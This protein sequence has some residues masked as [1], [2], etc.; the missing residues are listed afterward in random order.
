M[1]SAHAV[2]AGRAY[3]ELFAKTTEF[4]RNFRSEINSLSNF[5]RNASSIADRI[6]T[7][8][9]VAA[10][11]SLYS[12]GKI[13]KSYADFD[14][15]LKVVQATT[16]ATAEEYKELTSLA[17][18]LGRTTS[19]TA[20]EV[21]SGMAQLG[22]A[23]FDSNEIQATLKHFLN[24]SRAT[25]TSLPTAVDIATAT[26]RGFNM[27]V[28]QA[29]YIADVLTATANSSAQTLEDLGEAFKYI[30]PL[31]NA[32]SLSLKETA[33]A[34]A[35]LANLGIKGSM[36]A[37][38]M[39]NILLR[40]SLPNIQEIYRKE[41][42][43]EV[44]DQETGAL[45]SFNEVMQD[46]AESLNNISSSKRLAIFRDLFG[47][48]GL[49]SGTAASSGIDFS[50]MFEKID[51][52]FG[53]AQ[54][55]AD[56]MDEGIGGELRLT[57]SKFADIGI[58]IGDAL[59]PQL[60][61]LSASIEDI[62][63]K[64]SDFVR[65]SNVV[66]TIVEIGKGFASSVA[67][68]ISFVRWIDN[69]IKTLTLG[70]GSLL[71]FTGFFIQIAPL[72]YAVSRAFT[73][74][75]NSIIALA[76]GFEKLTTFFYKFQHLGNYFNNAKSKIGSFKTEFIKHFDS[77]TGRNL[78]ARDIALI[79]K[80]DSKI[81]NYKTKLEKQMESL[82][83][84]E[85]KK[86]EERKQLVDR[87]NKEWERLGQLENAR[88]SKQDW[89]SSHYASYQEASKN[90]GFYKSRLADLQY[91]IDKTTKKISSYTE[92]MRYASTIMNQQV[93]NYGE[94]NSKLKAVRA[95]IQKLENMK[96]QRSINE[97]TIAKL[98]DR[99]SLQYSLEANKAYYDRITK[100]R[101]SAQASLA[102]TMRWHPE[103]TK[104]IHGLRKD[105]AYYDN[106]IK[107]YDNSQKSV[108]GISEKI[109]A[110]EA[111]N[112]WFD[113]NISRLAE[114]T[115]REREYQA[116]LKSIDAKYGSMSNSAQRYRS[117]SESLKVQKKELIKEFKQAETQLES[118][119]K[120]LNA[121]TAVL[122]QSGAMSQSPAKQKKR[123]KKE[124]EQ[125]L[126]LE[127]NAR[128]KLDSLKKEI[129]LHQESAIRS[130][131]AILAEMKH[132]QAVIDN[133]IAVRNNAIA[134]KEQVKALIMKRVA[135]AALA[136]GVVGTF[137]AV[138]SIIGLASLKAKLFAKTVADMARKTAL[139]GERLAKEQEKDKGKMQRLEKI[140]E[141]QL[142]YNKKNE[143]SNSLLQ[144]AEKIIGS[145]TAKYGDLGLSI[146]ETT[147][148]V[149]G[150]TE[151]QGVLAKKHLEQTIEQKKE[152]R[153]TAAKQAEAKRLE[154]H[155][156][157][158]GNAGFHNIRHFFKTQYDE[159]GNP[160]FYGF[161]GQKNK[162]YFAIRDQA[163]YDRALAEADEFDLQ[164]RDI[165]NE[166]VELEKRLEKMGEIDSDPVQKALFNLETLK[167]SLAKSRETLFG[168]RETDY[169]AV[170]EKFRD[171]TYAKIKNK[172]D[173]LGVYAPKREEFDK[174]FNDQSI[175][176]IISL[177]EKVRDGLKTGD[178]KRDAID[179]L[180]KEIG[181]DR[182]S[183]VFGEEIVNSKKRIKEINDLVRESTVDKLSGVKEALEK[184]QLKT[185][186]ERK[187]GSDVSP[188]L[189][190]SFKKAQK[191]YYE[192][193]Y[194]NNL[195]I[196]N[197]MKLDDSEYARLKAEMNSD[198]ES[199][200]RAAQERYDLITSTRQDALSAM[201]EASNFLYDFSRA[202]SRTF[203]T[204]NGIEAIDAL[205]GGN[206]LQDN[207]RKKVRLIEN[208]EENV[209][210]LVSLAKSDAVGEYV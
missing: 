11:G 173:A 158:V 183:L 164:T 186:E 20:K 73:F 170:Y 98:N 201:E 38:G 8:T 199:V 174:E 143:V 48:Y 99:K 200:A 17:R 156:I 28:S 187:L 144:E 203:G 112:V 6:N 30:I 68:I 9:K 25:A 163:A 43:V 109:R 77:L 119:T 78:F 65:N 35:L 177:L 66:D 93:K 129:D 151:A 62:S 67:G 5:A 7:A 88:L 47:L 205:Y 140:N 40:M 100:L 188:E 27:E 58:A 127:S 85:K 166:I 59:M 168:K 141:E 153:K 69:L 56:K 139:Q 142:E 55:T 87:Y 132:T 63:I 107:K 54:R 196:Y 75:R 135:L 207:E 86:N 104:K 159:N 162:G 206:G 101:N 184:E 49:A 89:V 23:G 167:E 76:S 171:D 136:V 34:T 122:L 10:V 39:R 91:E 108:A 36:A 13:I 182:E 149:K 95:E 124:I 193:L 134:H 204:F 175:N 131:E 24:L 79:D 157:H 72:V 46:V 96:T 90:V 60:F 21:A 51:N 120:K 115:Q 64:V 26:L 209:R 57:I 126:A 2:R 128:A 16:H 84:F 123:W 176:G 179:N 192:K 138:V 198:E 145:L 103:D 83:K 210:K 195:E 82:T 202:T 148:K 29:E 33:K 71:R 118:W 190:E 41:L 181:E 14:D 208:L 94:Y 146:D 45:R 19:F 22:R 130:R 44:I 133:S 12:I 106:W 161:W 125:S 178:E 121:E 137:V 111:E 52:S 15:N 37:T 1:P 102:A 185:F 110:L 97:A 74:T 160:I 152:E 42:G 165:D 113:R 194:A 114:L 80:L 191:E 155:G 197:S 116:I 3:I 32:T 81:T 53:E 154:A 150:L 105:I 172:M 61:N 31:A 117:I 147:G 180:I 92:S 50:K 189:K 4:S 169:D 18:E 70:M